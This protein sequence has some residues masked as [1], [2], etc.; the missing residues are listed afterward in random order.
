MNNIREQASQVALM[1]KNLA[2]N[3]GDLRDAGLIPKWGK[4][5]WSR[6]WQPIP[7]LLLGKFH[8]QRSLVSYS[9][10]GH[11]ESDM[12]AQVCI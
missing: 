1:V 2:A 11:K 4:I 7:G 9:S 8:G 6:K 5:P 3:A 10:W 12:T